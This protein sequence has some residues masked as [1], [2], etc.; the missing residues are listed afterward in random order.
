MKNKNIN[1]VRITEEDVIVEERNKIIRE[2]VKHKID[3][4]VLERMDGKQV[5]SKKILAKDTNGNPTSTQD[6]TVGDELASRKKIISGL[7]NIIAIMD[8]MTK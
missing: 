6:I 1:T 5:Y 8:D 7:E 2:L 3:V 4:R